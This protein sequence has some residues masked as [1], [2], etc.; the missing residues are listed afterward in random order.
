MAKSENKIA[1]SE[2]KRYLYEVIITDFN[3]DS[4]IEK[5]YVISE[6]KIEQKEG[7][8]IAMDYRISNDPFM[9]GSY[10]LDGLQTIKRKK[11]LIKY[12]YKKQSQRSDDHH[13]EIM[14]CTEIIE[15]NPEHD[16]EKN[17]DFTLV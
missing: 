5:L 7:S 2:N 13:I 4:L 10:F 17:N 8:K 15:Y 12:L 3:D 16:E 9:F 6:H 14:S 11:Q 1:K